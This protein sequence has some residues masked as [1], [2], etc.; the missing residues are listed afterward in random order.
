M[1]ITLGLKDLNE[2]DNGDFEEYYEDER[3]N[4][5]RYMKFYYTDFGW[6][7]EVSHP[8]AVMQNNGTHRDA[9]MTEV[10]TLPDDITRQLERFH[11]ETEGRVVWG[12]TE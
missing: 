9:S 1:Q 5:R 4:G 6:R 2:P 11:E 10:F 7:L 12:E 8:V 3:E